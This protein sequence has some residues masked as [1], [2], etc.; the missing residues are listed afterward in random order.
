MFR[1]ILITP[2]SEHPITVHDCKEH[3]VVDFNEDDALIL[4]YIDAA[5]AKLDGY[6][7]VLGRCIINQTWQQGF[8]CFQR[9]FLLPVP[10]V[11]AVSIKYDDAEGVEQ[12]IPA[13]SIKFYPA[14]LGTLVVISSGFSFAALES[15]NR[16]PVR[17]E[18]TAGFGGAGDVP[19][20]IRVA[21]HQIVTRLY[22][23][24]SG[25]NG[26]LSASVMSLIS[27]YRWTRV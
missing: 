16:A 1:P 27:N 19:Q 25:D 7:G 20:P 21:I 18:F 2:P 10:D 24:R 23:D 5:M 12:E 13:D 9:E 6:R 17:V 3:A 8:P 11:S 15:G 14:P 22:E 26:D 4:G